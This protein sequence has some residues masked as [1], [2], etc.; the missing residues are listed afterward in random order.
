MFKTRK[1]N[2]TVKVI[3]KCSKGSFGKRKLPIEFDGKI[4]F[5]PIRICW[6]VK[7]GIQP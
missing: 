2:R 5:A 7:N 1:V 3:G 6:R 4:F